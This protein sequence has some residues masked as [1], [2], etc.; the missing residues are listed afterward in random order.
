MVVKTIEELKKQ[1]W[2]N[3]LHTC[4]YVSGLPKLKTKIRVR[5]VK[6]NEEFDVSYD[7]IR[8]NDRPH[9]FCPKCQQEDR[10]KDRIV[11]NCEYCGKETSLSKSK[12]ERVNY[13]FCCRKC[14][15]LAQRVGSGDKFAGLH[16]SQGHQSHYRSIAFNAYPHCC[17]VCGWN[18]DDDVLDV[19][20]IDENRKN[21]DVKNLIIL[22]PT[23][24]KKLSTHKYYLVGNKIIKR[25]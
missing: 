17:A 14:K 2:E 25:P 7:I 23:C 4:E 16:P 22:C 6:H 5:C 11:F 9:K 15:D 18:E 12:F 21:N 3:S 10:L 1:V 8:R 13:H 24:H 20:H 19:H